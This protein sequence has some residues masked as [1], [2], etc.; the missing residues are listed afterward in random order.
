MRDMVRQIKL[1]GEWQ[2]HLLPRQMPDI[3]GWQVAVHYTIGAFPGGDYYDFLMLHDGRLLFF[4]GDASD[5]GGPAC[6]LVALTRATVHSCPLSS[7]VARSPFCPLGGETVQPPHIILGNLSSVLSENS[8]E[9]QYMTLFC[10]VLNPLDGELR[11]ANAGHPAPRLWRAGRRLLEPLLSPPGL[12][13]GL[14]PHATYHQRRMTVEP[15]DILLCYSDGITTAAN[16]R[17]EVF[18]IGRLEEAMRDLAPHGAHAL[19]NGLAARLLDFLEEKDPPDDVTLL[20]FEK[21]F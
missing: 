10:G 1:L 5:E 6:V 8:L 7:G 16:Q 17:G 2:R 18:G 21:Q 14:E 12:P 9:E 19:T 13:L 4:I 11:F 3:P 15:G 20:A